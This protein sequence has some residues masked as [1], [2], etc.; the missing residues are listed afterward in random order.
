MGLG[1]RAIDLIFN[2]PGMQKHEV[3]FQAYEIRGSVATA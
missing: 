2:Y 3:R 1:P